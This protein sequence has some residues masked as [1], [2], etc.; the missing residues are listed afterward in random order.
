M[1]FGNLNPLFATL[2]GFDIIWANFFHVESDILNINDLRAQI[3]F[4]FS[5][6]AFLF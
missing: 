6:K 4:D 5:E 1:I 3:A 2:T